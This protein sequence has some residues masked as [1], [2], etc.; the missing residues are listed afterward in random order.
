MNI[1]KFKRYPI[2]FLW[3]IVLLI[4][5]GASGYSAVLFQKTEASSEASETR[6]TNE[7]KLETRVTNETKPETREIHE[8]KPETG[9][10]SKIKPETGETVTDLPNII[11]LP[12]D[13]GNASQQMMLLLESPSATDKSLLER[14]NPENQENNSQEDPSQVVMP[15]TPLL[16]REEVE[17]KSTAPSA[18]S[19]L[20]VSFLDIGQG[21]AI[22][23]RCDGQSMLIDGGPPS[24]SAII[25][26]VLGKKGI[27]YLDYIVSSHPDNDH[28][29]G[30]PAALSYTKAG[31]ALSPVANDARDRFTI[32]QRK[33]EE[34]N[35]QLT[36]PCVGDQF[37]L[38][39]AVVTVLGPVELDGGESANSFQSD[40]DN[41]HSLV[42]RLEYDGY[43]FLFPG[44][45]EQEEEKSLL[46]AGTDLK[47]DV[48]KVAHH[49]SKN[50][51]YDAWLQA[52]EPSVAVISC[53]KNNTYGHPSEEALTRLQRSTVSRLFRTDL[54]GDIT[55][56]VKDGKLYST[57]TKNPDADVWAPRTAKTQENN[58]TTKQTDTDVWV[59]GGKTA[60]DNTTT[61]TETETDILQI[62]SGQE[63]AGE[64]TADV[65]VRGIS[66]DPVLTWPER[67]YV[68]NQNTKKFHY[69]DCK[70]AAKISEKNRKD[71]IASRTE[72]I[73]Q[74]YDPC[75]NCNP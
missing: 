60:Q 19:Y 5:G 13:T 49:G 71:V 34:Q 41:N 65:G 36:I 47:C 1:T 63:P 59:P 72:L 66:T 75:K 2:L 67:E 18:D 46:E 21:D 7:I 73:E 20:E 69:P 50:S 45:A 14:K 39:S 58:T 62:L 31:M 28:L 74:G 10:T 25:Y 9:E 17:V 38:G 12:G 55:L 4:L 54:Q 24:A 8:T 68:L 3:L 64:V 52:I 32:F 30:L 44:D 11:S 16:V 51:T 42:L 70:S 29:G 15:E 56:I 40:K 27:T 23:I 61:A 35:L 33:L 22:L 53:G 57:V 43:R 6:A 37:P 48:L 26:T